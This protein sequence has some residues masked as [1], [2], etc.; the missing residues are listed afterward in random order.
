[1]YI[2]SVSSFVKFGGQTSTNV[3]EFQK[4]CLEIT[5][6]VY[7]FFVEFSV[8]VLDETHVVGCKIV[9]DHIWVG[10]VRV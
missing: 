10:N 1:M 7:A 8:F 9:C 6:C 3:H 5:M 4:V 2:D